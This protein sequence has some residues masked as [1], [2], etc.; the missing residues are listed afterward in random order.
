VTPPRARQAPQSS[1]EIAERALALAGRDTQITVVR[2]RSLLSRFARSAP[3]QATAVDDTTVEIL[4]LRDGHAAMASTNRLDD[5][6]LRATAARAEAAWQAAAT[7]GSGTHPGLAPPADPAVRAGFDEETA[8]LDPSRAAAALTA[9]FA[10]AAEHDLEAFGVWTA[11]DVETAIAATTGLRL[12][13]RVTDAFMKVVCRDADGRSGYAVDAATAV[14][15]IDPAVLAV[16]SAAKITRAPL[17]EL[18]PGR[19]PVV[20]EP[21]A[22]GLL[23]EFLGELA[24][25]GLAHA[26]GR[27]AL[28]G[29]LGT[30][31]AAPVIS[32]SDDPGSPRSLPR[33][34]DMEGVP[35]AA[36]PLI[37]DGVAVNVVHD[38]NSA[39]IA[40][41]GAHS[42]GHATQPG[43]SPWGPTPTNLALAGGDAADAAALAA[44]I[45]RGIYV[46]RLWYVNTVREKETLLTGMTRDGTFLIED[47]RITRPLRDVRF[48][49]SI[50]RLLEA[51]EALT[52]T[53]RLVS[54]GEFYGRR[55]AQAVLCPAL[56]AG[57]FRITG[58]TT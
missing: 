38:R 24:H 58:A 11:G 54:E 25:N 7:Q 12:H 47:G 27:G 1:L 14:S 26:E 53:R 32:L 20:L 5:D 10:V 6:A 55:F 29:R 37:T 18:G 33:A 46:T 49:D 52:T 21:E 22:V 34:F 31:V 4:C 2:E 16:R 57:D 28:S 43:G 23:L 44:P 3:T 45:E 39:A 40:G 50:L 42:T 30:S 48:T 13:D 51:T 56:R 19:Y 17:A 35:K 36:L 41:H 15:A 8:A 9:A